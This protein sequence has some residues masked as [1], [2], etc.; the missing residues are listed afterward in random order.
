MPVLATNHWQLVTALYGLTSTKSGLQ[1]CVAVEILHM[2][3]VALVLPLIGEICSVSEE[4]AVF[5]T[6]TNP[7][8]LPT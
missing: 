1:G 6:W 5:S 8:V 3:V 2:L 4:K 7:S